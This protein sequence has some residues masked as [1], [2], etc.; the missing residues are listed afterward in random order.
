MLRL[1]LPLSENRPV[2]SPTE[3]EAEQTRELQAAA[4]ALAKLQT[5]QAQA[6]RT[7]VGYRMHQD[8]QISE[9]TPT[10]PTWSPNPTHGFGLP[11]P[12]IRN[13]EH[14]SC[15]APGRFSR[16]TARPFTVLVKR[17]SS[18]ECLPWTAARARRRGN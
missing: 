5:A 17:R 6:R 4:A 10:W 15:E 3:L 9:M 14:P 12:R 13:K 2:S 16:R 7:Y 8:P 18:R 1:G 11:M